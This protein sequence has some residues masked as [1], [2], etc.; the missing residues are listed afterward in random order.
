MSDCG[1]GSEEDNNFTLSTDSTSTFEF[2]EGGL[3]LSSNSRDITA[4]PSQPLSTKEEK[5][6]HNEDI[7]MESAGSWEEISC[8]PSVS[9]SKPCFIDASSLLDDDYIPISFAAALRES[10]K[11]SN[12][13]TA[14]YSE[15]S[16]FLQPEENNH[17][18]KDQY[19]AIPS[20]IPKNY[21]QHSFL[22]DVSATQI[23]T[24]CD[25]EKWVIVD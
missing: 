3:L 8:R 6:K 22:N 17:D 12:V 9:S 21:Q 10:P 25:H 15:T 19:S 7:V 23:S 20:Y 13:T 14:G 18:I 5:Q 16:S 4:C 1:K 2:I 11:G 24:A